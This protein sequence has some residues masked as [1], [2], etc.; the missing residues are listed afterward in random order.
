MSVTHSWHEKQ[1]LEDLRDEI[2]KG[3][4]EIVDDAAPSY[5]RL[6]GAFPVRMNRIDWDAVPNAR[7]LKP[8]PERS[9][10][11]F[12]L[13]EPARELRAFWK[14]VRQDQN[15]GDEANVIVLG[16]SL[17][18]FALRLSVAT[19]T[20]RLVDILSIPHHTYVFPEDVAWCFNYTAEDDGFFGLRPR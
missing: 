1:L 6:M 13:V 5:T 8:P 10:S 4:V 15:I 20:R 9:Q 19:L 17:V 12:Q 2:A 16:D 14:Q 3:D 18:R 11:N 7:H